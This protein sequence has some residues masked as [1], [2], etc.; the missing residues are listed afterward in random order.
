MQ[1]K[2][3]KQSKASKRTKK[4]K[5]KTGFRARSKLRGEEADG[6]DGEKQQQTSRPLTEMQAPVGVTMAPVEETPAETPQ[7]V[8]PS[9]ADEAAFEDRLAS[10]KADSSLLS[11]VAAAATHRRTCSAAHCRRHKRSGNVGLLWP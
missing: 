1:G 7:A 8:K 4:S 5:G 2:Q 9:I 10:L 6:D 3:A 11:K